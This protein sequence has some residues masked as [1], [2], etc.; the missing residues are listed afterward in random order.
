MRGSFRNTNTS[1]VNISRRNFKRFAYEKRKNNKTVPVSSYVPRKS[2]TFPVS[3]PPKKKKK[4]FSR[5]FTEPCRAPRRIVLDSYD[6]TRKVCQKR[7][8]RVRNAIYK[9][10]TGWKGVVFCASAAME[11]ARMSS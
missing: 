1:C 9:Y 2:P 3:P 6:V 4:S 7:A 11:I 5:T 8:A 10:A